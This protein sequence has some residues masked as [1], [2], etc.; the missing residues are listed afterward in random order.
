MTDPVWAYEPVRIA[1]YDP[2][3]PRRAAELIASLRPVLAG[4]IEHVGSTA[5][6]GLAAKPVIDLMGLVDSFAEIE[7]I[8]DELAR[9]G[10][11]YVP[12]ELDGREYRRFF[13]HVIQDRRSAHLHL[14]RPGTARWRQQLAFRDLLR[15]SP[16]LRHDYAA[17]KE[18]L[19]EANGDDREAY[20]AAKASFIDTA[21]G[22]RST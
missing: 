15:S 21:L 11:H 13:V 20:S 19:A 12:P 10:W 2:D 4:V 14:M 16:S 8:A 5:V 17:L 6:P 18:R 9:L 1:E 7:A 3:W 22:D